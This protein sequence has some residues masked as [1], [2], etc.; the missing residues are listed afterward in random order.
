[1]TLHDFIR[2]MPKAELHVHLQGATL[3]DA[4]KQR[5]EAA[6]TGD[7]RRLRDQL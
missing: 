7:F 3:L 4:E 1:M 6:F 2:A 5:M